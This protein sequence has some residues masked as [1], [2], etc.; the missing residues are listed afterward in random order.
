M[1]IASIGEAVENPSVTQLLAAYPTKEAF[2]AAVRSGKI[3]PTT[4]AGVAA[5]IFNRIV[6][7]ALANQ[8][9]AQAQTTVFQDNTQPMGLAAAA[10]MPQQPRGQGLDQV[11]VPPEMFDEQRMAGGGIVAFQA[12]G[13][14][15]LQDIL[16]QM[17]MQELEYYN[18]TGRLPEKYRMMMP[19]AEPTFTGALRDQG[20]PTSSVG[21]PMAPVPSTTPRLTFGE[22]TPF[23]GVGPEQ[24]DP[25]S[26][27][28]TASGDRTQADV[29]FI[30]PPGTPEAE[31]SRA[32][33][34]QAAEEETK[35]AAE[36]RAAAPV[37]PKPTGEAKPQGTSFS[38]ILREIQGQ[39]PQ[40]EA[41]GTLEKEILED[42]K[43]RAK[44]K[45]DAGW[46]RLAEA[47]LGIAGGES[48][49][50]ATNVGK[51]AAAALKGYAEDLREQKKLDREDKKILADIEQARR[52][53]KAGNIKL[54]S[55]RYERA[56]D[57]TSQ[58]DQNRLR[59]EAQL[60][61]AAMSA[62]RPSDAI[63]LIREM[64]KDPKFKEMA[65]SIE[66]EKAAA[67]DPFADLIRQARE[68]S[69]ANLGAQLGELMKKYPQAFQ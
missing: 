4:E 51:G 58:A 1:S 29:G 21:A 22:T 53:E 28:Q 20:V 62:S 40:G 37:A 67:K 14:S 47:G 68:G 2:D 24:V 25:F 59:V 34:R 61:A 44:E 23:V 57:R 13:R 41:F 6:Q 16:R 39:M 33:L 49:Y 3:K 55:E 27:T 38:D 9:Q 7:S 60:Q 43:G 15:S 54:A 31:P 56:L 35:K 32:L 42:R 10:Q 69:G 46:L 66:R 30:P 45:K 48:P 65:L 52:A 8:A 18:R 12:G 17:S 63:Q 11:P 5:N 19:G 64:M 36:R 50:F 26:G